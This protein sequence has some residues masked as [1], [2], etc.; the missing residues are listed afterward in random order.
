MF[1]FKF[2]RQ[3]HQDL[4]DFIDAYKAGFVSLYADSGIWSEDLII[5]QYQQAAESLKEAILDNV[6]IKMKDEVIFGR[7][8]RN[9][10]HGL[11]LMV[12]GRIID[13]LYSENLKLHQRTVERIGVNRKQIIF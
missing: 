11:I 7:Q 3:A 9:E 6:A 4:T 1:D 12:N 8:K 13:V 2:D 5:K 10:W